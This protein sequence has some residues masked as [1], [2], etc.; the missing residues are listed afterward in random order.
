M[1]DVLAYQLAAFFGSVA[2]ILFATVAPYFKKWMETKE[3]TGI[4]LI[5][6]KKFA[7]TAAIGFMFAIIAG[8]LNFENTEANIDFEATIFKTFVASF[9]TGL[10]VTFGINQ[11]IKPSSVLKQVV[12]ENKQLKK[13]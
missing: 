13:E 10:G 1:V 8:I 3:V 12:A 6:D 9:L 4:D 2:A 7:V 5:F 11:F